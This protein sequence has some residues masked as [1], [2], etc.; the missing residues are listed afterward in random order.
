MGT[1]FKIKCC[2]GSYCI[3]KIE[4]LRKEIDVP[5]QN[6]PLDPIEKHEI[7]SDC[8]LLCFIFSLGVVVCDVNWSF[9]GENNFVRAGIA[10][11]FVVVREPY[12]VN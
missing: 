10:E 5:S 8:I 1:K 6:D 12:L 4:I 3:R 2:T 9:L 7:N 11:Y